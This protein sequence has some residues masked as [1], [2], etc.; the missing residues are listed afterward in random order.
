MPALQSQDLVSSAPYAT[1]QFQAFL[2][3]RRDAARPVEDGDH[4][5]QALPRLFGAA[6]RE[7]LGKARAPFDLDVLPV[8][9][10]GALPSGVAV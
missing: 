2:R 5:A 8:E 4:L 1:A 9:S 3:Q 10:A 6:A 7:A